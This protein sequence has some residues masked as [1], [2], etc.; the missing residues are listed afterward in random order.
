[1]ERFTEITEPAIAALVARFYG[2]ARLDPLIGPVFNNTID[3][4]DEHLRTL[5]AFWSS[6]MLTSGRYKGNPMAAHLKLP[7]KPPVLRALAGALARNGGGAVRARSGGTVPGKSRTHRRKPQ[8]RAVLPARRC[9][10]CPYPGPHAGMTDAIAPSGLPAGLV[11]YRRTPIFDQDTIPAGLRREHSTAA[12]IWGPITVVEG[13][14]CFRTLQSASETVLVPGT[15]IAVA[16][17]QP[18]EV[19]P[20]GPVRFFVEFYR[21]AD[22]ASS[23]ASRA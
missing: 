5:N 15:P 19:D 2:K 4:W 9:R 18:H 20:D 21:A 1:M 22:P 11:A 17:Q 8:A 13:R 12:G 23:D 6:V 7:I 3:D 14:L 10:A 16:P